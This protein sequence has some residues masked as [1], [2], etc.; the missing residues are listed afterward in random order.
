VKSLLK[1]ALAATAV[2]ATLLLL[3][4]NTAAADWGDGAA[5][6]DPTEAAPGDTV[7]FTATIAWTGGGADG[8]GAQF[9]STI[10]TEFTNV[11]WSCSGT[12]FTCNTAS[13]SGNSIDVYGGVD[14]P[15]QDAT[16]TLTITTTVAADAAEG[17]VATEICVGGSSG[18][19]FAPGNTR[20]LPLMQEGCPSA[21]VTITAAPTPTP[22]PTDAPTETATAEPTPATPVVDPTETPAPPVPTQS[23]PAPVTQL[24]ST[25]SGDSRSG[26]GAIT[27]NGLTALLA[28]A[29]FAVAGLR[30]RKRA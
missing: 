18:G 21:T 10:P 22:E 27:M 26:L 16:A 28:L 5:S 2:V 4:A 1:R 24:P 19:L 3:L 20:A 12:N 29:A 30:L 23:A 14:D 6:A 17:P 15:S 11:S 9:T 13:G 25:G 8:A 7:T